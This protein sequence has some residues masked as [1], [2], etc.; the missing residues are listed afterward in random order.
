MK[1]SAKVLLKSTAEHLFP[2]LI[3]MDRIKVLAHPVAV[4]LHRFLTTGI[5]LRP[6]MLNMEQVESIKEDE[7]Y[8]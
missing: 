2:F 7:N 4:R 8:C 1:S 3:K 6:E 5:S